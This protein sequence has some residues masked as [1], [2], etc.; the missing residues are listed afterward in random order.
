MARA[1]AA[2]TAGSS[3]SAQCTTQTISTDAGSRPAARAAARTTPAA[4]PGLGRRHQVEDHPV[5]DPARQREHPRAQRGQVDGQ[6]G[7]DR[8]AV[9]RH[10]AGA[11]HLAVIAARRPAQHGPHDA[12]VLLD[13]RQRRERR[14]PEPAVHD[15]VGHAQAEHEPPARR[16]VELRRGLGRQHRRPQ[17]RVRDRGPH[18]HPPGR[19]RHRMAQGQ[20]VAVPLG[21]EHRAEPGLLGGS[22][23]GPDRGRRQPAVRRDRQPDEDSRPHLPSQHHPALHPAPA[24]RPHRI[25]AETTSAG[26]TPGRI[27]KSQRKR[28]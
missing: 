11:V 28:S 18:P 21:H 16:V 12:D 8:R 24:F 9:E 4:E 14:D 26:Q 25:L 2:A 19:G 22:G 15:R 27:R 23:H 10:H 5:G 17:R 7:P 6:A 20:G 13:H 3:D 1:A